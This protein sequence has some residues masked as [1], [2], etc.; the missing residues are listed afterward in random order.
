MVALLEEEYTA[1]NTRARLDG[2][3]IQLVPADADSRQKFHEIIDS[4]EDYVFWNYNGCKR[5]DRKSGRRLLGVYID[6]GG[7]PYKRQ[8]RNVLTTD[9]R[10]SI[11]IF[12]DIDG[13]AD[14][15]ARFAM[16]EFGYFTSGMIMLRNS[17]ADCIL[18]VPMKNCKVCEGGLEGSTALQWKVCDNCHHLCEHNYIEGVGIAS[19]NVAWMPFCDKC[20]RGNPT[21]TAS[22]DPLEDMVA[23]VTNNGG[24]HVLALEHPDGSSTIISKPTTQP[25]KRWRLSQLILGLVQRFLV[26]IRKASRT[27]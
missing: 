27:N 7:T 9:Y 19:G 23:A 11:K 25:S 18:L 1:V 17:T 5:T 4:G 15:E 10:D 12:I 21:W 6:C 24:L 2:A 16:R 3:T 8:V 20:G 22:E 13:T 26:I 14:D